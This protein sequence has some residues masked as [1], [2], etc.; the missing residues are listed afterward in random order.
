MADRRSERMTQGPDRAPARAMLKATGLTDAD[1]SRPIVAV[2]N[3]WT[4]GGPCN[5]HLRDLAAH[6]KDGIRAAGGTPIEW[7]TI[8]VSDGIS[9]G[10]DGMRASLVSRGVRMTAPPEA[11]AQLRDQVAPG[12][13]G[14]RDYALLVEDLAE[15][16]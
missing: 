9:M 13:L 1:L 4:E 14:Q 10:T 16:A 5:L 12:A 6:V 2:I 11:Y 8:A 7:G 15:A 3:T